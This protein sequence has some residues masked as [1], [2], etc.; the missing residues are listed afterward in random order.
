MD[1][2][3][4]TIPSVVLLAQEGQNIS[5]HPLTG[6]GPL[7]EFA[8][9]INSATGLFNR[10]I[11]LFVGV[12]TIIAGLWF[13]FQFFLGAFGWLTAGSDKAAVENAQKRITNSIIGLVVIVAAIFIVDLIGNLL[14]LSVLKPGDFILNIWK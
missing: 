6:I 5:S 14:G 9:N 13:I 4:I 7:G 12:L 3:K 2:N 1:Q 11:S 8:N 10:T